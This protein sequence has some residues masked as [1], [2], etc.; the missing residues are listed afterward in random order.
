MIKA[1]IDLQDLRRK[2]YVKVKAEWFGWRVPRSQLQALG[3]ETESR[4]SLHVHEGETPD[5][6]KGSST[7]YCASPR[8]YLD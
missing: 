8:P 2:I 6:D 5:T 1:P 3:S 7:G 4:P